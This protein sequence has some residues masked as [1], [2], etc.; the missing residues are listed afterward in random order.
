M[1]IFLASI[2]GIKSKCNFFFNLLIDGYIFILMLLS[3][4]SEFDIN[5]D[6]DSDFDEFRL[7]KFDLLLS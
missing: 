6:F 3:S 1:S 4:S 5:D 7:L 2:R